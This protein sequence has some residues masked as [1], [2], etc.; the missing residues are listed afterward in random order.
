M[1]RELTLQGNFIAIS[2]REIQDVVMGVVREKKGKYIGHWFDL[3]KR[4][5]E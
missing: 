4:V 1:P 3:K 2:F 5:I